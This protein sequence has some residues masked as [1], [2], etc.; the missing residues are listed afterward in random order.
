MH[1]FFSLSVGVPES[2][3]GRI[4]LGEILQVVFVLTWGGGTNVVKEGRRYC[5]FIV[6]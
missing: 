4:G 1:L 3:R 5:H 2:S 6:S